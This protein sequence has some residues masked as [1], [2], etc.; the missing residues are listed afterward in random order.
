MKKEKIKK[1]AIIGGASAA[2]LGLAAW[3]VHYVYR[4]FAALAIGTMDAA[5]GV[6]VVAFTV[7]IVIWMFAWS[8]KVKK[9]QWHV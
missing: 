1:I 9:A 3:A 6:L 4:L 2:V 7:G 5:I 8:A